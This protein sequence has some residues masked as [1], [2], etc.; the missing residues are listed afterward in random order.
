VLSYRSLFNKK[1]TCARDLFDAI[2]Q[3]KE[4]EGSSEEER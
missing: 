4:A 3:E 1:L 2:N